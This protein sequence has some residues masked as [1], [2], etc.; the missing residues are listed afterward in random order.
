[1]DLWGFLSLGE[2]DVLLEELSSDYLQWRGLLSVLATFACNR[3]SYKSILLV[4][5]CS[6]AIS[7]LVIVDLWLDDYI[8][9]VV[10]VELSFLVATWGLVAVVRDDTLSDLAI[11]F[12]I[13][14]IKHDEEE[15]KT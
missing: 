2:G 10:E 5:S 6:L 11:I 1:V 13:F 8:I 15:I 4:N 7:F 12:W 3:G 14:L 9:L